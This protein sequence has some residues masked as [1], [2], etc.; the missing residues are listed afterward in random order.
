MAL[1]NRR[2]REQW[3]W[4]DNNW[5]VAQQDSSESSLW[6]FTLRVELDL[7]ARH[8]GCSRVLEITGE[9]SPYEH[10]LRGV[11]RRERLLGWR[12]LEKRISEGI[13]A[14]VNRA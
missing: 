7:L 1:R 11:A 4:K 2:E 3:D 14:S 10:G 9:S 6:R 8:P 13:T 12:R 5:I